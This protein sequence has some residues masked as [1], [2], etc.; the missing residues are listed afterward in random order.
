MWKLKH[1]KKNYLRKYIY[2]SNNIKCM[3]YSRKIYSK[4]QTKKIVLK[5]KKNTKITKPKSI[6]YT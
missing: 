3:K 5:T 4:Y 1:K 6:V 2:C